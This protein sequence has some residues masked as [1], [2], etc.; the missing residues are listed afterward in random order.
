MGIDFPHKW[1][2]KV[3]NWDYIFPIRKI[4]FENIEFSAPNNPDMVLKTIYGNYSAIPK[5]SYPRHSS[6]INL[7]GEEKAILEEIAK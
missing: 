3:F 5:D 4:S 2:R 1:K 7:E 6:Y